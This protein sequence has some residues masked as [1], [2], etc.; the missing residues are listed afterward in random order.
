MWSRHRRS[1]SPSGDLPTRHDES[2]HHLA[3]FR[4]LATHD[5]R[6][7]DRR[8]QQQHLLHLPGIDVRPAAHD[9]VLAAI[10]ERE[11]SVGV[12][13]AQ[14]SRP[15]P[16]VAQRARGAFEV[17][18][19]ARHHHLAAH[20]HLAYLARWQLAPAIVADR[21]AH[22]ALRQADGGE[23][24][25]VARVGR[26]RVVRLRQRR[27]GHRAFALSV[28]LRQAMTEGRGGE[29][30]IGVIH[31][32]AA[33]YECL[34]AARA[35]AR[36]PRREREALHHRGCGEH[37]DVVVRIQQVEHLA[38]VECAGFGHHLRRAL[39]EM[40]EIVEAR[41]MRERCGVQQ[42]AG[43]RDRVHVDEIAER[44]LAEIA[45]REHRALG[46]PGGAAGIEQPGERLGIGF[47]RRQDVIRSQARHLLRRLE[48]QP[49]PRI[50][51]D[52]GYFLRMQ[53]GVHRH[54]REPRPPGGVERLEVFRRVFHGDRDALARR[55][56]DALA[57][58]R[59][60]APDPQGELA[61]GGPARPAVEDRGRPRAG[62]GGALQSCDKVHRA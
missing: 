11:E 36:R 5:A 60:E 38:R 58:P 28:D 18:P 51:D 27:D 59:G 34:Q 3:P 61:I 57:Q 31:R 43:G 39:R 4:V 29:L 52:E 25:A 26:V 41:A 32:A 50:G 10:L 13:G 44:H 54:H 48:H 6:L 19:V 12:E 8:M 21:N 14:V 1:S 35:G 7:P 33:V 45:V 53:P 42:A 20:A 15:K 46:A 22:H 2:H 62:P 24:L 16:A 9:Q 23:A 17:V 49:R 55:E 37:R 30:E 47:G 56:T 40:G